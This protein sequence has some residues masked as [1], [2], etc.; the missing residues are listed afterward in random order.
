MFPPYPNL[1]HNV[2]PIPY[3]STI[4]SYSLQCKAYTTPHLSSIPAADKHYGNPKA[5][6]ITLAIV[7]HHYQL[8]LVPHNELSHMENREYRLVINGLCLGIHE[9]RHAMRPRYAA[10]MHVQDTIWTPVNSLISP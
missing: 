1:T 6:I 10:L 9:Y 4:F 3:P 8:L 5:Q 7:Q 2:T